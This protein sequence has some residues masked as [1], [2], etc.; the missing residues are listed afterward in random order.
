MNKIRVLIGPSKDEDKLYPR[1]DRESD[2]LTITSVVT[3]KWEYGIDING[4]M[5]FD[6]DSNL[7]LR[8]VDLHIGK[9]M[10]D[11]GISQLWPQN[12]T[13]GCLIFSY[14]VIEKKSFNIPINVRY[15]NIQDVLRVDF[16]IEQKSRAILLS[17]DCIALLS[18]DLL[19]GFL[20]KSIL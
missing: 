20:V 4:N 1:Y 14:E 17:E 18:G 13:A 9:K 3:S 6:I 2:I 12:A 5:V 16:G 10:W 7:V 19:V 15:D 11:T 8:N